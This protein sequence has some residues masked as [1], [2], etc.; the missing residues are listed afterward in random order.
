MKTVLVHPVGFSSYYKYICGR[1]NF[2][3]VQHRYAGIDFEACAMPV[4]KEE[5]KERDSKKLIAYLKSNQVTHV[6]FAQDFSLYPEFCQKMQEN[7]QVPDGTAII[8]H[9]IFDIIRK[10]AAK[11][12]VE[13]QDSTVVLITDSP[14]EAEA[15][16]M[17]LYR[18]VK[19]IRI[20]TNCPD[21]FSK[22]QNTCMEEYGL[23]ICC[24]GEE[25]QNNEI[26]IS[27]K[28]E[29]ATADFCL[30]KYDVFDYKIL[31]R[32]KSG[33]KELFPHLPLHEDALTF[34]MMKTG[35]SPTEENIQRFF[36]E[37]YVKITKIKNND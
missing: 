32:M 13:P 22:L 31:L 2:S 29:S 37:H 21:V 33:E 6:L 14:K 1:G 15:C 19:K 11:K 12:G 7:F 26:A 23:Y 8:K 27:M 34:L 10:C 36:K 20:Q 5:I 16:I 35:V 28:S 3:M 25:I 9:K 17:R 24:E 30:Q 4:Y 18:H